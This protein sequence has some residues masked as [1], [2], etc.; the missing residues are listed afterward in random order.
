HFDKLSA[1]IGAEEIVA[2]VSGDE[3]TQIVKAFGNYIIPML[4]RDT[5]DLQ[6]IGKWLGEHKVKT[7]AMESLVLSLSK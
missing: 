3:A 2:C 7:V 5:V 6:S 1:G 4:F